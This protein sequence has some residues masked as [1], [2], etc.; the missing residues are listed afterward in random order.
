MKHRAGNDVIVLCLSCSRLFTA[1]LLITV[2]VVAIG[3]SSSSPSRMY[4]FR[5]SEAA[6]DCYELYIT[7]AHYTAIRCLPLTTIKT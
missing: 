3:N 1:V 2:L 7:A 4:D 5:I 6:A